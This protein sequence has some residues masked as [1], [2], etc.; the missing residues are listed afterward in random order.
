MV[1]EKLRVRKARRRKLGQEAEIKKKGSEEEGT[2]MSLENF[3][4]GCSSSVAISDQR[5]L[6]SGSKKA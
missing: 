1:E 4:A 3:C 2:N 6:A 5:R